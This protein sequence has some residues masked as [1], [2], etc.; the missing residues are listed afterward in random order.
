MG[1]K[2]GQD[3]LISG[4]DLL[5]QTR[6]HIREKNI[7]NS[8][9][10]HYMSAAWGLVYLYDLLHTHAP[11]YGKLTLPLFSGRHTLSSPEQPAQGIPDFFSDQEI[12]AFD[13][14]RY[15]LFLSSEKTGNSEK[16]RLTE[17]PP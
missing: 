4:F 1:L 15:S 2:P 7:F 6:A 12:R 17:Q 3:L 5:P 8:Y 16:K 10:G 11:N 14:S 9:G 13:F